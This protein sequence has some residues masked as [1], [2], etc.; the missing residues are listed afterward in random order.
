MWAGGCLTAVEADVAVKMCLQMFD[1]FSFF[2]ENLYKH[3]FI[4]CFIFIGIHIR[5][6]V[7]VQHSCTETKPADR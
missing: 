1:F 5:L 4:R 3:L 2:L 6:N 7:C